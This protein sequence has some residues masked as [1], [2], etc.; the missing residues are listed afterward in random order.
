M[1]F[2]ILLVVIIT[3]LDFLGVVDPQIQ[4]SRISKEFNTLQK[5]KQEILKEDSNEEKEEENERAKTEEFDEEDSKQECN[6]DQG[7][8]DDI[9]VDETYTD[10]KDEDGEKVFI[11]TASITLSKRK[12]PSQ[13]MNDDDEIMEIRNA[14]DENAEKPNDLKP[15]ENALNRK[16]PDSDRL[17][18]VIFDLTTNHDNLE[19]CIEN[20]SRRDNSTI[21]VGEVIKPKSKP[22]LDNLTLLIHAF[23][24]R[25]NLPKLFNI[26]NS[27]SEL[28]CLHG[29]RFLSMTWYIFCSLQ[30]FRCGASL[31]VALS[32]L[33]IRS[34]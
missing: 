32:V 30:I 1:I 18:S 33:Q 14:T 25:R 26:S 29:I 31:V 13:L 34:V 27:S 17:S 22:K 23:S 21:T 12:L 6:E 8:P 15:V 16:W 19:K 2:C 28:N 10:K 7:N 20:D 3:I 9:K 24:I 4:I 5:L 11:S